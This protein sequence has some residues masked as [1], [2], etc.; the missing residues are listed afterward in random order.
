[1]PTSKGHRILT[2]SQSP[3]AWIED[4]GSGQIKGGFCHI[5]LDPMLLDCVTINEANPVKVFVQLTSP[6]TNQFY[7]EKGTTG[8]DVIVMGEGADMVDAT[9]DYR[10]VAARKNREKQRFVEAESPEQ[11]QAQSRMIERHSAEEE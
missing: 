5:D 2:T 10:V 6:V 1:M 8:F 3:E 9:F 4:Y 7:V 11:V